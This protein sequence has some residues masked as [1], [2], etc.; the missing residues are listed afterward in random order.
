MPPRLP[1]LLAGLLDLLDLCLPLARFKVQHLWPP[2]LKLQHPLRLWLS[3]FQHP[4]RLWLSPVSE[5]QHPL[6]L[7]Q[8]LLKFQHALH[9]GL[10]LVREFHHPLCPWLPL[11]FKFQPPLRLCLP[12]LFKCQR[13]LRPR[14]CRLARQ[15]E[16]AVLL[17]FL[18]PI[19]LFL[20]L[21]SCCTWRKCLETFSM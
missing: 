14:S 4:L 13:L 9:L 18:L 15:L 8:P 5:F 16:P 19:F 11:L 20:L 17:P 6:R 21:D 3:E 2:L 12:L 10:P 1:L 7:C